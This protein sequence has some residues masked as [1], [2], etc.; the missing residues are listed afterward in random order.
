MRSRGLR[1]LVVWYRGD[2]DFQPVEFRNFE[3]VCNCDIIDMEPTI[4]AGKVQ[5]KSLGQGLTI[6][7]IQREG[8]SKEQTIFGIR[9]GI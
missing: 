9:F 4:H 6:D 8:D 5:V 2:V 7:S 1:G 3:D